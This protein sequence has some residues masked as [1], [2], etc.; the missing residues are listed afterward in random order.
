MIVIINKPGQ[1]G[2]RLFVFAHC[3]ACAAEH[4][5]RIS[6]P[7]FDEYA[8]FFV[9]TR[10]DLLCRYP[11]PV[12]PLPPAP[13]TRRA[14][15]QSVNLLGLTVTRLGLQTGLVRYVRID[16]DH[17]FSLDDPMNV[18]RLKS[19]RLIVLYGWLFRGPQTLLKHQD[20]VRAYLTPV[21]VHTSQ[22][23]NLITKARSVCD[24]LVGVHIRH[25]DYR[26]FLG[27]RYFYPIEVYA[28]LMRQ[29]EAL[30][31]TQRV[32]FLVCSNEPLPPDVLAEFRVTHGT[33]HLVEDM[34]AFARCDYI[35]GPPSTYTAWSSFY[36]NV[37][38]H[39]VAD[40][41][42]QIALNL[43]QVAGA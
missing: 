30:F 3:I 18:A 21:D 1:L 39:H 10:N 7:S 9:G 19:A 20:L 35:V 5:L 23:C 42:G 34:Y 26:T 6:N 40:P 37:P 38:M 16:W 36:G 41:V 32:G 4:G 33:N 22:I 12:R 29:V 14:F 28:A 43:F 2:N 31:P 11:R 15:F 8:P 27:G 13:I 17:P 25:G 24:V